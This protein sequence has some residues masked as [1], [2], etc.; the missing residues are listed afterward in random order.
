MEELVGKVDQLASRKKNISRDL[1]SASDRTIR[2]KEQT[3]K[4]ETEPS[5]PV[6]PVLSE[7]PEPVALQVWNE[8]FE[9]NPFDEIAAGSDYIQNTIAKLLNRRQIARISE[10]VVEELGSKK[11]T[12]I[13]TRGDDIIE[14]HGKIK[15]C[16]P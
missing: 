4:S 2:D 13:R 6:G 3:P 12:F 5:S 7:D 8:M 1:P 14:I 10:T 9:E 16:S 11:E 15:K